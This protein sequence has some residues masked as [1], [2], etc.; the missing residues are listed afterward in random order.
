MEWNEEVKRKK[1][2][3]ETSRTLVFRMSL[4]IFERR[5]TPVTTKC[6]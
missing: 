1:T 4:K 2:Y 5:A 6:Q 3:T